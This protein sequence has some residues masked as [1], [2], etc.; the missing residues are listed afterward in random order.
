[1]RQ[2]AAVRLS[3]LRAGHQDDR[4]ADRGDRLHRRPIGV[5]VRLSLSRGDIDAALRDHRMPAAD[6]RL[7]HVRA[8][9]HRGLAR[10]E[11][12][13][14]VSRP[15]SRAARCRK[16]AGITE[17]YPEVDAGPIVKRH[18]RREPLSKRGLRAA[19]R[20][21]HG[22]E[23]GRNTHDPDPNPKTTRS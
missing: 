9:A 5:L 12:V 3:A 11:D 1:M 16:E 23:R 4:A 15:L 14:A 6:D 17:I 10:L 13:P 20:G 21:N 8:V 19:Q 22:S 18:R 7:H 2:P